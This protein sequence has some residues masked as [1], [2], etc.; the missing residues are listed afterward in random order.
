ML[1]L[2]KIMDASMV[3]VHKTDN[4]GY[5]YRMV[6]DS[7]H[8]G[9]NKKTLKLTME[10]EKNRENI[11]PFDLIIVKKGG[12]FKIKTDFFDENATLYPV[13]VY[14]SDDSFILER[15][16]EDEIIYLHLYCD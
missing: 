5:S 16:F 11:D 6:K 8:I 14:E 4:E 12:S 10:S 2:K 3:Y 15:I 7:L 1:K 13:N 9:S